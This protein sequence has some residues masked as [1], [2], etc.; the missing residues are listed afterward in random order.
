MDGWSVIASS[1]GLGTIQRHRNAMDRTA[2]RPH[3]PQARSK[4][5]GSIRDIGPDDQHER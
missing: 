1:S 4:R 2:H 3:D 5:D